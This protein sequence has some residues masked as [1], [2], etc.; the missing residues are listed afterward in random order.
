MSVKDALVIGCWQCLALFPGISRSGSTINAGLVRGL[1]HET[2]A[3]FSLLMAQPAVLAAT[4]HEAWKLRSMT[5]SSE[6]MHISIMA[7]IAAGVTALISTAVLLRYFRN[8][9]RWAL[10]PFA[11]YCMGAGLVSILA[12]VLF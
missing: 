9:D 3:R 11:F 7:A 2:A 5:V 8:H 12:I 6:M 10:S 1:D 4:V